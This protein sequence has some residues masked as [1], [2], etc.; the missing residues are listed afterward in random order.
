MNISSSMVVA[1]RHWRK[2]CQTTL[3][4]HGISEACAVPLLMIGRLGEGVRQVTVA[5][6]AGMESPSLVRLLDQLCHGGYVC[7]TEDAQDRRAKCL[8]LTETG[9]ELVQT[10]EIELVRLRHVVLDGIDPSD[11]EATLR[12]LRAFEA[13]TPPSVGNP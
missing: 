2:I 13:A 11:L 7:R 3:A 1:A 5:H 6:A 8:S 12:V 10:V 9:R 4:N